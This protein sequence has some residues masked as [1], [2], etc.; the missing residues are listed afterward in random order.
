[1]ARTAPQP[2]ARVAKRGVE[3]VARRKTAARAAGTRKLRAKPAAKP[4]ALSSA[5][6]LVSGAVAA[7]VRL[8]PW[9]R[10]EADPIALLEADHRRFEALFEAGA[11]TTP[12]AV[13]RRTQLLRSLTAELTVHELIEEQLLY[14]AGVVAE[15]V[16]SGVGDDRVHR[17]GIGAL[18]HHR[19]GLDSGL[20]RG[21]L[22]PLR[23][24]GADDSVAIAQRN[25]VARDCAR[26]HQAVFDRL[27]AVPVAERDLVPGHGGH[28]D[29]PVRHRSAVGH[30]VGAVGAEHLGGILLVLA[31]E[32]G[33]VEQ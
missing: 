24:D 32:T 4:S 22:E 29:H 2:R 26:H 20:E 8:L 31:H 15:P 33:V 13:K 3:K 17:P 1:M 27:V 25:Q 21:R 19:V 30:R 28:E 16:I 6:A 5:A 23:G 9:T 7:A 11:A 18:R 12:R 10:D 14:P